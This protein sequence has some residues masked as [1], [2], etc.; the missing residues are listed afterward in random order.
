MSGGDIGEGGHRAAVGDVRHLDPGLALEQVGKEMMGRT[1][2][3]RSERQLSGLVLGES[4]EVRHR[5][6][7]KRRGNDEHIGAGDDEGERHEV[8]GWI[9]RK[10]LVQAGVDCHDGSRRHE[11]SVS[12][13][14]RA[15][16]RDRSRHATAA[17][18]VLDY[19]RLAEPLLQ[20]LSQQA[21][22]K[23]SAAAGGEGHDE[24]DGAC[25]IALR[26]GACARRA[27]RDE[28]QQQASRQ[29]L[30]HHLACVGGAHHGVSIPPSAT[31]SSSTPR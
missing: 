9:I 21:R 7:R 13:G 29:R 2:T 17:W 24:R 16:D 19:E 12:V 8:D 23:F 26:P 4:D 28:R 18:T 25:G 22:Q 15:R 20:P 3:G 31:S 5:M 30:H 1:G 10:L 27:H 11:N 14:R 6:H